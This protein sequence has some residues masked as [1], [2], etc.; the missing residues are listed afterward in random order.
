MKGI[1]NIGNSC[2]LNSAVQMLFN[3]SDFR[4]LCI[5]TNLNK[6]IN[7][8]DDSDINLFNPS[9]IKRIVASHNKMFANN[10]QHDSYEFMIYLFD[11]L[12][13]LLGNSM[14]NELYNKFVIQTT[15]NIKC[16]ISSCN[17]ES[18]KS[19]TE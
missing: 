13:K 16:K 7:D 2:Y 19:I 17:K 10:H 5:N 14:K 9:E 12:D 4:K 11:E 18:D 8:Y 15:T 6:I 3:C 1:I